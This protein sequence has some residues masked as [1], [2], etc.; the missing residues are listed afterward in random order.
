MARITMALR[1]R[2]STGCI[3][4][5]MLSISLFSLTA[6]SCLIRVTSRASK[7]GQHPMKSYEQCHQHIGTTSMCATFYRQHST[8]KKWRTLLLFH[9]SYSQKRSVLC[10]GVIC[11]Q[12]ALGITLSIASSQMDSD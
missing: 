8:L 7:N 1:K 9:F 10:H 4:N 5:Y 2:P 6:L 3:C 12:S 11:A